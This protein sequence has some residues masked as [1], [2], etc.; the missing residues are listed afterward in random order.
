M[1]VYRFDA[2]HR[3]RRGVERQ[4]QCSFCLYAHRHGRSPPAI[5][6]PV[7]GGYY[8]GPAGDADYKERRYFGINR[9]VN[10]ESGKMKNHFFLF[11]AGII[12]FASPPVRGQ[13][14]MPRGRNSAYNAFFNEKGKGFLAA[15][16]EG[17]TPKTIRE[18]REKTDVLGEERA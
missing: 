9:I 16:Q 7:A 1:S 4:K 6:I 3:S 14:E 2:Y 11:A 12:L 13:G 17:R 5:Y 18:I 8:G 10:A 15:R